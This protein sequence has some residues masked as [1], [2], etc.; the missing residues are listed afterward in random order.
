[1][2]DGDS[3]WTV[4]GS[5]TDENG[6]W[7]LIRDVHPGTYTVMNDLPKYF[8]RPLWGRWTIKANQIT[9]FGDINL[10]PSFCS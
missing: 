7:F 5:W 6:R 4:Q 1:M 2:I 10:A 3:Y 8:G 9:D